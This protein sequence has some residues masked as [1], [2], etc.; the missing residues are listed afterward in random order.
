MAIVPFASPDGM[1]QMH[2]A[3]FTAHPEEVLDE[4]RIAASVE[5]SMIGLRY[6]PLKQQQSAASLSMDSSTDSTY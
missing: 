2:A 5:N 1:T 6:S 3:G 4:Q